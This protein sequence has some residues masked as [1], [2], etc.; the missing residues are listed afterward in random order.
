MTLCDQDAARYNGHRT[1]NNQQ[2]TWNFKARNDIVE[3]G[4]ITKKRKGNKA[5]L[6]RKVESVFSGKQK[7]N[8][9]QETH[10]VSVMTLHQLLETVAKVRDEKD[11]RLL[12][13]PMQR[14]N[15]LTDSNKYPL[16]DQAI[17]RKTQSIRVKFNA[18]SDYFKIR[19]VESGILPCRNYKSE[20]CCVY[21]DK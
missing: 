17:N 8:V 20:K 15:R 12:P 2:S 10:V 13:P 4:S 21:G 6:Q 14:Q 3:R 5:R 16:K 18:D 19:H 1:I 9:P 7:D 11:D